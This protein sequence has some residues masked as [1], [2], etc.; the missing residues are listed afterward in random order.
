MYWPYAM[1]VGGVR[2]YVVE[3]DLERAHAVI[4][5]CLSGRLPGPSKR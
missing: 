5:D 3:A 1:A 2:V 4:A